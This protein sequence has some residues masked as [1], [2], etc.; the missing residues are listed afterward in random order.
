MAFQDYLRNTGGGINPARPG[1]PPPLLQQQAPPPDLQRQAVMDQLGTGTPGSASA[2]KPMGTPSSTFARGGQVRQLP[3]MGADTT[4]KLVGAGA[5]AATAAMGA[6][7]PVSMGTDYLGKKL[8]PK[9]EMPTFGGEFGQFTDDYGRRFEGTGPGIKGGAVRGAGYGAMAGPIG[10]GVGALAGAIVGAA[11]KNAPSAF[12]DFRVEDAAEAIGN[13]YQHY[14]GRPASEEEISAQM[15]AVGWDPTG[16]DRWMGE[17]PLNYIF[18]TLRDSEEARQRAT[19]GA[20][21]DQLGAAPGAAEAVQGAAEGSP[22]KGHPGEGAPDPTVPN[23]GLPDFGE[24]E[25][26]RAT[27]LDPATGALI[28]QKPGQTAMGGGPTASAS[29]TSP[30]FPGVTPGAERVEGS[31]PAAATN[32]GTWDTDGYDAPAVIAQNVSQKAPP[33]WDQEKW[34][35][36]DHQTPKYVWGR[37][38]QDDNPDDIAQML[39]A[40][41]GA[42]FDGKDKIT[43]IPGLGPIDVYKGASTG[44]NEP[45]WYD[46]TAAEAEGGGGGQSSG[47]A[48]SLAD[49]QGVAIPDIPPSQLEQIRAELERIIAGQPSRDA[50][51]AQMGAGNG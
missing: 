18:G 50:L 45:Q 16:G 31:A 49:L 3:G 24:F 28:G 10:A 6:V 19:R 32:P 27:F 15:Q 22:W 11:T 51:M 33:G 2:A 14:L 40:Y 17:K 39:A 20:V 5:T 34:N 13:A 12:S 41:P 42:S 38:T 23:A 44:L 46:I 37:I 9:E 35:N 47:P 43:G 30:A 7:N 29:R 48:R 21:M 4:N 25:G 1:Q 8:K 26:V 36:P